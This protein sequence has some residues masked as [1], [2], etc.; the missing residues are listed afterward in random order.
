M[1][2][3][4]EIADCVRTHLLPRSLAGTRVL[5]SSGPT[6]EPIDPVRAITNRSSGKMGS[7]LARAALALGAEVT[8]VSGPARHQPPR[9]ARTIAVTTAQQ[10]LDALA[11]EFETADILVMAAAVADFRPARVASAKLSRR[12]SR[13]PTLELAA[14]PDILRTLV[15]RKTRQFVAGFSLETGRGEERARSKMREKRCDMMVLNRPGQSL[16]LDRATVT[17]MRP[18]KRSETLGPMA[19][20]ELALEIMLRIARE[21][22]TVA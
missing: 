16:E 7:A 19:K 14:N 8:V 1:I 12:E 9:R 17:V 6:L 4:E 13:N 5:I 11:R 20:D 15:G 22:G 18:G 10:M 2:D 3:I 21:R